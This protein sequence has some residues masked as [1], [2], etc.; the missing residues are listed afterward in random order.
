MV[1]SILFGLGAFAA[2]YMH[3]ATLHR[4]SNDIAA[5]QRWAQS[6]DR[7]ADAMDKEADDGKA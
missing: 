4:M 3:I 6:M 7:W 1:F 2:L 5:L